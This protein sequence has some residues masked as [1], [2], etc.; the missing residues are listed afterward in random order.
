[1]SAPLPIFGAGRAGRRP[2]AGRRGRRGGRGAASSGPR[3][4]A[5]RTGA[6]AA[7]VAAIDAALAH[8]AGP[9]ALAGRLVASVEV[10]YREGDRGL[11]ELLDALRA[12]RSAA[13]RDLELIHAARA[14]HLTLIAAQ[15]GLP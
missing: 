5:P 3:P 11:L 14:A 10:A 6:H 1:V 4:S 12:T 7:T 9:A 8:R 2:G 13:V 15:A